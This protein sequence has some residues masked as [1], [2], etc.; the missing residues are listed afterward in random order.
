MF[1]MAI[2]S[3]HKTELLRSITQTRQK[4]FYH[5]LVQAGFEPLLASDVSLPPQLA[6]QLRWAKIEK[7]LPPYLLNLSYSGFAV[8][9]LAT[10][11]EAIHWT[12][13]LLFGLPL[14]LISVLLFYIYTEK[15]AKKNIIKL[16]GT[17]FLFIHNG[18]I[19]ENFPNLRKLDDEIEALKK[20]QAQTQQSITDL[21]QLAKE[22][23]EKLIL[24]GQDT[25][26]QYLQNLETQR[27][28]QIRLLEESQNLLQI[29][30]RSRQEQI[31]LQQ[32]LLDWAELDRMRQ[33]AS[34]ISGQE[35]KQQSWQKMTELEMRSAELAF[36]MQELNRE[37]H[38]S[39]ITQSANNEVNG[40]RL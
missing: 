32:E 17:P 15:W 20:S 24:L 28:N 30:I 4:R 36:Q 33:Q 11:N 21:K 35:A 23:K 6:S 5:A 14:A 22:M 34:Q 37:L 38:N 3:L 19:Y 27:L 26:D 7:W 8:L 29:A 13:A 25:N 16:L 39:L 2:I 12:V 18:D 10:Q 1:H 40:N 31:K 9:F